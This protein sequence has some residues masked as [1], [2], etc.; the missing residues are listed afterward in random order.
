M[1]GQ[2]CWFSKYCHFDW[3]VK[4]LKLTFWPIKNSVK[5]IMSVE[6]FGSNWLY[7]VDFCK[8]LFIISSPKKLAKYDPKAIFIYE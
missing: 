5:K 1:G 6:D 3:G 8:I 4:N 2:R 7:I